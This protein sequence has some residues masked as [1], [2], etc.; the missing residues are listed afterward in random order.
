MDFRATDHLVTATNPDDSG[1]REMSA[2][3][4]SIGVSVP[5]AAGVRLFLNSGLSFETP[6]TTELANQPSGAGGF[7]PELEPQRTLSHEVGINASRGAL[8]FQIVTYRARVSDALVPFEVPT[9]PGRQFFRNAAST[10][11]RGVEVML[12][13]SLQRMVSTRIAYSYTDARYRDYSIGATSFAGNRLP[14]VAPHR[15]ETLV[16]IGGE[17]AFLDFESRYQTQLPVNDAN[18]ANSAAFGLIDGRAQLG[19]WNWYRLRVSPFAGVE[20]FLARTY[21]ASVVVNAAGGRYYEPGP[22]RTF[23][24]VIEATLET[25]PAQNQRSAA[26]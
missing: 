14:G 4:P 22:F 23:F 1:D 25:I 8:R 10:I 20:N 3:S 17:T 5:L 15:L 9:A 11:H 24:V 18:T 16:R 12:G 6:T 19:E 21:N 13:T 2:W 7:N 26:Q